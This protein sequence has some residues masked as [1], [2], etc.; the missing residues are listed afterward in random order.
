VRFTR[1]YLANLR[2]NRKI[3]NSSQNQYLQP[4]ESVKDWDLIIAGGIY[5]LFYH[6]NH[7][8]WEAYRFSDA[9]NRSTRA[10]TIL[11]IYSASRSFTYRWCRPNIDAV[12][13]ER[14][15]DLLNNFLAQDI[16]LNTKLLCYRSLTASR[17]T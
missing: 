12:V 15:F 3:L 4:L 10:S 17:L 16:P 14:N 9:L 7:Q 13:T 11:T 1:H 6:T 2:Q 8:H 5:Q